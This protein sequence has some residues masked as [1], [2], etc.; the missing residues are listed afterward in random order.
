MEEMYS[1]INHLEESKS[2]KMEPL[3]LKPSSFKIDLPILEQA[4]SSLLLIKPTM[5]QAMAPQLQQSL[6]EPYSNKP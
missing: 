5:K 3:L 4:W 2:L 6:L 1:L